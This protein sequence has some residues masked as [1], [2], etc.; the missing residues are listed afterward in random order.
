MAWLGCISEMK[1]CECAQ[2]LAS[3]RIPGSQAFLEAAAGAWPGRRSCQ[4]ANLP[5]PGMLPGPGKTLS[6][7]KPAVTPQGPQPAQ[8]NKRQLPCFPLR[9]MMALRKT[10]CKMHDA[11]SAQTCLITTGIS[12]LFCSQGSQSK[13]QAHEAALPSAGRCVL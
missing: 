9:A 7:L 4:P 12:H 3:L 13:S 8:Q 11:I 10:E 1:G 2:T 5:L 6:A